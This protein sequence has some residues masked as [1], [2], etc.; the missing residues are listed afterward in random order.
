M[1]GDNTPGK[2]TLLQAIQIALGAFLQ[3][4]SFLPAGTGYSRIFRPTDQVK[5]YI[6]SS[7]GFIPSGK[8]THNGR[9]RMCCWK[10]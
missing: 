2:T 9:C 1:L 10:I 4:M 8:T 7:K 5:I 6:E 3:E